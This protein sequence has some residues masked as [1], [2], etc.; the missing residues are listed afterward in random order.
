MIT[1][2]K[3]VFF[4]F[5][6]TLTNCTTP[7]GLINKKPDKYDGKKVKVSGKVISSLQLADIMCFTLKERGSVICVVTQNYLPLIGSEIKVKGS[8]KKNYS[9]NDRKMMVVEENLKKA[10]KYKTWK[11]NIKNNIEE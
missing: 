3:L 8:F 9:Y 1:I 11:K 7:I 6:A 2:K 10:K 5:V 4:L